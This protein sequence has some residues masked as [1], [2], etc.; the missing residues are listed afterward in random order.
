[1]I[2]PLYF[3]LCCAKPAVTASCRSVWNAEMAAL[4]AAMFP[5]VSG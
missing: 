3:V 2:E 5:V 4:L 1:L